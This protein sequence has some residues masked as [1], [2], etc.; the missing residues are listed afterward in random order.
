MNHQYHQNTDY[1][2]HSLGDHFQVI[3]QIVYS[4]APP[5]YPQFPSIAFF[6]GQFPGVS[7]QAALNG[8]VVGVLDNDTRPTTTTTSTKIKIRL[9][10]RMLVCSYT[11]ILTRYT[12]VAR[13]R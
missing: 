7:L 13:I 6:D 3:P 5:A 1:H 9:M 8:R 4:R 11:L 12:L 2:P 10:V